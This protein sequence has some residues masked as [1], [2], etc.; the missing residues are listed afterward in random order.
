MN[1]GKFFEVRRSKP[2]SSGTDCVR[3]KR[4]MVESDS[5]TDRRN[6]R[7]LLRPRRR[8]KENSAR[9]S[10][11]PVLSASVTSRYTLCSVK[12]FTSSPT[13][14]AGASA[15]FSGDPFSGCTPSVHSAFFRYILRD[16]WCSPGG[17]PQTN[18]HWGSD[19]VSLFWHSKRVSLV[20][21]GCW[22]FGPDRFARKG[23]G[24]ALKSMFVNRYMNLY[25]S[26]YINYFCN[27]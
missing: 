12:E 6:L 15:S 9:A 16:C 14:V 27:L 18:S 21:M 22:F 26:T 13:A 19:A 4:L 24:F 17:R 3:Q 2:W 11:R 1:E 8:T 20:L 25:R 5:A 7:S 10:L 23:W